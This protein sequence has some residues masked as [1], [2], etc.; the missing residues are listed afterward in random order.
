MQINA[1]TDKL[2]DRLLLAHKCSGRPRKL[3]LEILTGRK[4]A[5]YSA[6]YGSWHSQLRHILKEFE[7]LNLRRL[8]T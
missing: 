8:F 6:A 4:F 1:S 5:I 2:K 3:L 7:D